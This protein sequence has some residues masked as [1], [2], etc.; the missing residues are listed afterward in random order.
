[1]N[2]TIGLAVQVLSWGVIAMASLFSVPAAAASQFKEAPGA[3]DHPMVGRFKDALLFKAGVINFDR[4]D[5]KLP[6]GRTESAEGKIYN[7]YYLG[8]K[9]HSGLEVFRN[10]KQALEQQRFKILWACEDVSLCSKQG[11]EQHAIK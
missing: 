4:V 3:K 7:Y 1:M 5:V 11:L 6:G 2:K 9:A 8:P 10:Y